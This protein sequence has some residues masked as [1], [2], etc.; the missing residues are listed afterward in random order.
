MQSVILFLCFHKF[1]LKLHYLS[2]FFSDDSRQ[3]LTIFAF[4]E[5][6]FAITC[7]N[8]LKLKGYI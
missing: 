5:P 8:Q 6:G 4:F 1:K 7:S 2:H 3:H